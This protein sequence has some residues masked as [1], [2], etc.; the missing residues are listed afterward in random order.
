MTISSAVNK[1]SY[2][3]NGTSKNFTVPFYFIYKSD[4]KVY[5][6]NG[7]VQEL[8]TLDTDYTIIGTPE[9]QDGSIYR[10]GGTVVMSAMPTAGTRFVILR[11]VPLTQ[12]ADYQEGSTFPAAL[13]E[14]ALDKLTMAVQQLEEK[15]DR[16]VTVDVFSG[17]DPSSLVSEI[18]TIYNIKDEVVTVAENSSRIKTCSESIAAIIDAPNQANLARNSAIEATNSAVTAQL[19][20]DLASENA[21]A[22][23]ASAGAAEQSAAQAGE[24]AA[25]AVAALSLHIGDIGTALY[26]DETTWL[27]RRLNGQ[28]IAI[29]DHTQAFLNYLK[30]VQT[31]SPSL[32]IT[33]SNWQSEKT[34]SKLGQCGKFVID[35]TAGTIRLPA[36]V[37]INGLMDLS[38]LGTL[39]TESLPNF[40]ATFQS[41]LQSGQT[42]R[43]ALTWNQYA[44]GTAGITPLNTGSLAANSAGI[45]ITGGCTGFTIDLSD[46]DETYQDGAPVQQ[47]AIQYPYFIQINTGSE[48]TSDITNEQKLNNPFSFGDSKY[49]PIE[50]NNISW[51]RSR[52]QW[53]SKAVYPA[54]YDWLLQKR[55]EEIS[56]GYALKQN[57]TV[58]AWVL[59]DNPQVGDNYYGYFPTGNAGAITSVSGTTVTV[60]N[61]NDNSTVSLT[62]D[63]STTAQLYILPENG[64][65]FITKNELDNWSYP[66]SSPNYCWVV[67]TSDETFRLPVKT[68]TASGSQVVGNGMTLGLTNGT[69]NGGFSSYFNGNIAQ[70]GTWTGAYGT[71]VGTTQ[72]GDLI[73]GTKGVTTDPTKSGIE[74]SSQDLYLYFYVGET[75][76]NADLIDAGRMAD[77]WANF[78]P[79]NSDLI[80]GYGMPS[81]EY[82]DLTFGASG[83]TYTAP[84]SGWFQIIVTWAAVN[85]WV[86]LRNGRLYGYCQTGQS[87][88]TKGLASVQAKKGEVVELQYNAV[89]GDSL[90]F[91]YAEGS[92]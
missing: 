82:V 46:Y 63:V 73:G 15:T 1:V 89:S 11:E 83:S 16:A 79:N 6:M 47:E 74:T 3:A 67:N 22:A 66:L 78:I 55:N 21:T 85:S 49:S 84:A 76:Q 53:N 40:K 19:M 32:F 57:D 45:N 29:N 48:T 28:V 7:Y 42:N 50:L 72:A 61:T 77:G 59:S 20:S 24:S 30:G 62:L 17:T 35:E 38:N 8:L 87:G 31:T 56:T 65:G 18:E 2:T 91:I 54:Y 27:R 52:G 44:I 90:V 64:T 69:Q 51:L 39:R 34:L 5:R 43:A 86:W 41:N 10:N 23:S 37:N 71:S 36:V 9:Q 26:V 81:G 12:E 75:V 88:A 60:H 33:E 80:A 14:L 25:Q 92:N 58:I 4:L 13:H 68:L 70:A